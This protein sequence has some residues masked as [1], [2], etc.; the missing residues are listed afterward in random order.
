MRKEKLLGA[1]VLFLNLIIF[2]VFLITQKYT[3]WIVIFQLISVMCAW[4]WVINPKKAYLF[5]DENKKDVLIAVILFFLSLLVLVYKIGT[6]R[7]GIY[8][9]ELS[10][11]SIYKNSL[12]NL[13]QLIPFISS[14]AHPLVHTYLAA[15]SIYIFGNSLFALRFPTVVFGSL[16]VIALYVLLRL[17]FEKKTSI[18]TS[19]IFIFSYQHFVIFRQSYETGESVFFQILSLMFLVLLFKKK[20]LRSLIGFGLA[21]GAGLY[22]YISIR[23]IVFFMFLMSLWSLK[24]FQFKKKILYFAILCSTLFVA[25]VPLTS[26]AV[27]HPSEF[28]QRANQLSVFGRGLQAGEVMKEIMGSVKN[29][30]GVFLPGGDPNPR[31]NPS[32]F[33]LYDPI[34][35]ILVILGAI[36]LLRKQRKMFLAL[37]FLLIP[38]IANDIFSIEIFPEFHDYGIGHPNSLRISGLI[39]LFYLL[40]AYAFENLKPIVLKMSKEFYNIALFSVCFVVIVVN[41]YGYFAQQSINL[42][43]FVYNYKYGNGFNIDTYNYLNKTNYQEVFVPKDFI[44]GPVAFFLHDPKALTPVEVDDTKEALSLISA[45]KTLIISP[46]FHLDFAK[47][48]IG[49][50]SEKGIPYT[51]LSS[52]W[53][54]LGAI[55]FNP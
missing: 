33:A 2:L 49:K 17:F 43:F 44:D 36:F 7:P 8:G 27:L 23:T 45:S 13:N 25:T 20:N 11:V 54:S 5:L 50:A 42:T 1:G 46:A 30:I 22:F 51:Q 52:P 28:W 48:L 18:V 39:P 26:Y 24:T 55:V 31:Y 34:T 47:N 16:S 21:L 9:D 32:G 53:G 29:D 3:T 37:M 35:S 40:V 4:I 14:Y 38:V 19:L 41:L 6:I 10:I 12:A 15:W